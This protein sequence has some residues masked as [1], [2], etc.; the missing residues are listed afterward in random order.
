LPWNNHTIRKEETQPNPDFRQIYKKQKAYHFL[1]NNIQLLGK[2]LQLFFMPFLQ[3]VQ[4]PRDIP[5]DRIRVYEPRSREDR[6]AQLA[7]TFVYFN[8]F[9]VGVW[10]RRGFPVGHCHYCW[11]CVAVW[12]VFSWL[13]GPK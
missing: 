13:E 1:P 3:S 11:G 4:I 12:K 10:G 2:Q 5:Q 9:I 7:E 8:Y 6:Y